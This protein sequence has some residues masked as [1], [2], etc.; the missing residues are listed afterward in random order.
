MSFFQNIFT[1]KKI[2]V[3]HSGTFHA[4]DIFSTATLSILLKGKIKLIRTRDTALFQSADFVYDV[5]GIYDPTINRF[6]H[7]Q[8]G[9]AGARENG[10]QYAAFGLVWKHYGEQICGS[11]EV[12]E[13]IDQRLVQAVDANDNGM[14]LFEVTGPTG[15]YT[16]QDMFYSFRP[17]WKE[18][19]EYDDAFLDMVEIAIG[20][21]Q[22]EI[23]RTRDA[24]DAES[25]VR[26]A[27][28]RASDKRIVVLEDNYPWSE[29]LMEYPEPIYA[30]YLKA[31]LW[32]CEGVRKEKF[33]VA[34]R[35][36]LPEAWAGLRDGD[37]A[38]VT[39]VPDAVFC[40]RALFLAVAKSREG[41]L[42]LAEKALI[43]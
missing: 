10:I 8:P 36:N 1:P 7:H 18:P 32:R 42:A 34:T 29:I 12:A 14:S 21:L 33:N 31:G 41:I 16:I 4:D 28:E 30:V 11:K 38:Q 2:L 5:G 9:G 15:P 43:A 19:E 23:L 27:Y 20:V 39:G 6:D 25:Q 37:L 17:S 22:R 35:K 24:L 13:R 40:H 3:T 26:E